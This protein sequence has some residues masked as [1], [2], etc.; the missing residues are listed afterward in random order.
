MQQFGIDAVFAILAHEVGH[1]FDLH[2][3]PSNSLPWNLQSSW[4]V[5]LRAD[6]WAGCALAKTNRSAQ[7]FEQS[8]AVYTGAL[9]PDNPPVGAV[10]LVVDES[11][12]RCTGI[13]PN[14]THTPSAQQDQASG[15]SE[16]PT[17]CSRLRTI[18]DDAP[19]AFESL[20]GK[21]IGKYEVMGSTAL[22]ELTDCR[23]S[24]SG[25]SCT[26]DNPIANSSAKSS[27][28][29]YKTRVEAC[30]GA[31]WTAT[32]SVT[33]LDNLPIAHAKYQKDSESSY[34]EVELVD[35]SDVFSGKSS[36]HVGVHA[37]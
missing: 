24:R 32:E 3:N 33:T 16:A 21:P 20:K 17:F 37:K 13:Q 8:V 28:Q 34:V 15:T 19:N 27:F 4:N 11:Y 9:G 7:P 14:V 35:D 29:M 31:G 2:F 30:L 22:D 1:H 36:V 25:Y 10:K 26:E 23:I 5:E 6:A 18:M 12:A